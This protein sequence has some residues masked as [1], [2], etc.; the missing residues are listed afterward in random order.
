MTGFTFSGLWYLQNDFAARMHGIIVPRL[1]AGQEPIP[2]HFRQV[3]PKSQL[4]FSIVIAGEGRSWGTQVAE[5]YTYNGV[6]VLPITG[7]M[8]R[9]GECN[10]GME[11][12]TAIIQGANVSDSVRAIVL[13]M[14]TPGGTVDATKMLAEAVRNS[15][16]PV[17]AWTNF[18]ASAGYFIASQA[19]EIWLDDQTVTKI[20]SIGVLMV[21]VDQAKAMEQ[22][23][24]QVSI[25]RAEGSTDK[26]LVNGIE[27]LAEASKAEIQ[28]DLN[29]AQQEFCGYVRRGRAGSLSSDDWSTGKMYG[30]REALRIGLADKIGGLDQAVK[31]ALQ[32]S[33]QS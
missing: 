3:H 10:W 23:G 5:A 14:D 16:K 13:K 22:K 17:V 15:Q 32:L 30:I 18:C 1:N 9:Y 19:R 29:A 20:G 21:Y 11:D 31:R 27:P 24:Y 4:G 26:A 12:L 6:M 8:S 28:A 33:K 25:F 2:G 7:S